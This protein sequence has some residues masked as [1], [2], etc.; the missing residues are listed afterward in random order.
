[1]TDN[2]NLHMP[3]WDAVAR[4]GAALLFGAAIGWEREKKGRAAGL[5][6]HILVSLGAAGFTIIGA[7]LTA[8]NP[9]FADPT[10]VIQAVAAGVGFL[11]AGTIMN[12]GP[13]VKGLT[14]AASIWVVAAVGIAAG[15]G[16]WAIAF[17]LTAFALITLTSLRFFE[18]PQDNQPPA[19]T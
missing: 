12:N 9:Q 2:L 4:L 1:M 19:A 7:E 16:L 14:T 18:R 8:D 10:R 3:L 15:T 17:L 13:K 11:G 6:T 5:R